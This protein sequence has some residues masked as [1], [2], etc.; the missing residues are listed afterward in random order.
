[1]TPVQAPKERHVTRY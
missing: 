1:L